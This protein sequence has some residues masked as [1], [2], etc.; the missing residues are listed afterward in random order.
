MNRPSLELAE[1]AA[2]AFSPKNSFQVCSMTLEMWAWA[3]LSAFRSWAA[4]IFWRMDFTY[5]ISQR[6]GIE[7]R[8]NAADLG[9]H[10]G[11]IVTV[12]SAPWVQVFRFGGFD[13]FHQ[14]TNF[15]DSFNQKLVTE[16]YEK[17]KRRIPSRSK[18]RAFLFTWPKSSLS[19]SPTFTIFRSAWSAS[20]TSSKLYVAPTYL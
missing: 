3:P 8:R 11:L 2:A 5:E 16:N 4:L 9:F 6:W 14:P 17:R 19:I 10:R 15:V 20:L 13:R 1:A 12:L 7:M 18:A